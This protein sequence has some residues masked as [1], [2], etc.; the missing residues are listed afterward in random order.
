MIKKSPLIRAMKEVASEYNDNSHRLSMYKCAMCL[1][2]RDND[3]YNCGCCPMRMA[4]KACGRRQCMPVECYTASSNHK[5]SKEHLNQLEAVREFYYKTIARV[6]RMTVKELNAPQA[7]KFMVKIDQE[8]ADK[9]G[10]MREIGP[11]EE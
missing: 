8:I 2:Y 11:W 1:T 3:A 9:Y 7:F 4:F 5:T 10:I 6:R